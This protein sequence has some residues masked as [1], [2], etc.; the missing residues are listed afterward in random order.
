RVT[1]PVLVLYRRD[2]AQPFVSAYGEDLSIS[3]IR[4]EGHEV[5]AGDLIDLQL[6]ERDGRRPLELL[7][8]VTRVLEG[9]FAV[10]FVEMDDRQRAWLERVVEERAD[11]EDPPPTEDLLSVGFDEM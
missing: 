11:R 1:F 9:E 10:R 2:P 8:Q 3:G 5:R 4:I 6:I 7:G